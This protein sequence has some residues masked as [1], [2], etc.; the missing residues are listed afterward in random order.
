MRVC[1]THAIGARVVTST[2]MDRDRALQYVQFCPLGRSRLGVHRPLHHSLPQPPPERGLPRPP[3]HLP[4]RLRTRVPSLPSAAPSHQRGSTP[5]AAPAAAPAGAAPAAAPGRC[6]GAAPAD[7]SQASAGT[8][9]FRLH[10]AACTWT[11]TD[12]V[13]ASSTVRCLSVIGRAPAA[14]PCP[15][16]H[17]RRTM[18]AAPCRH[19]SEGCPSRRPRQLL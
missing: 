10:L 12:H 18:P 2:R 13:R 8:S 19:T 11:C 4:L 14:A 15:P 3:P 7:A 1:K 6:H 5:F 9:A 17:A 16:H